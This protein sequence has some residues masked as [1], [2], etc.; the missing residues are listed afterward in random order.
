MTAPMCGPGVPTSSR[1]SLVRSLS[2]TPVEFFVGIG[3]INAAHLGPSK[4]LVPNSPTPAAPKQEAQKE[5]QE[6][7][8]AR[9]LKRKLDEALGHK[10]ETQEV[11][12]DA[13]ASNESPSE[14]TCIEEELLLRNDDTEL[15]LIEAVRCLYSSR[16]CWRCMSSGTMPIT[17]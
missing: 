7:I 12:A 3:D 13:S 16:S 15:E 6:Q 10:K 4:P 14:E 1:C 5:L 2:L 9:P 11:H 17:T 8:E